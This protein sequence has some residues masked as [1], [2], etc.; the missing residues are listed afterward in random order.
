MCT[1]ESL[2]SCVFKKRSIHFPLEII[3]IVIKFLV[4]ITQEFLRQLGLAQ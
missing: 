4:V 1:E 3:G 2:A